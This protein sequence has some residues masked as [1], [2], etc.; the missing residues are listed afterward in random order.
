MKKISTKEF[1][2]F[3][4]R[5]VYWWCKLKTAEVNDVLVM[6]MA[7]HT[8]ALEKEAR[9]RFGFTDEDFR[10][11]LKTARPGIFARVELWEKVNQR[12]GI[13]PALP[14]PKYDDRAEY[15]RR[16]SAEKDCAERIAAL[17]KKTADL[18]AY[19][20]SLFK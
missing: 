1:T 19:A 3:A 11:A 18:T 17:D 8:P 7:K 14:F 20:L 16:I 13:N 15:I 9:E 2:E 5:N 4:N 12:L 6:I 10:N